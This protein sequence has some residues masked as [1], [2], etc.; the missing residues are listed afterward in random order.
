MAP[1]RGSGLLELYEQGGRLQR[2]QDLP[3][4][5]FWS[6]AELRAIVD[7]VKRHFAHDPEVSAPLSS[8]AG[9]LF[10]LCA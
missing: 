7:A 8:P 10:S 9:L 5:A 2:R 3:P 1:L 6:A 4:E